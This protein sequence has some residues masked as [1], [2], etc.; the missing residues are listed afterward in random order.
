MIVVLGFDV[1]TDIG[2]WTPF[3]QGIEKG[4]PNLLGVL[5]D[6]EIKG[7]FFIT[8]DV[9]KKYPEAVKKIGIEGHEIGCHSLFHETIGDEMFPI[10]G[11]VPLLPEEIGGRIKKAT[12]IVEEIAAVKIKSFRAPRLWGSSKML[13]VLEDLGYLVDTSYPMFYHEK[14][15][16]P[17]HPNRDNWLEKGDMKILEIPIFADMAME[18]KDQ[19]HRDRDQ[20]PL[21]R[22]EGADVLIKHIENHQN[23]LKKKNIYPVFC[24]YFHPWEFT[25]M[26][27]GE[28]HYGEGS[29]RPDDFIVKNC[30]DKAIKEF[31]KL[32]NYFKNKGAKFMTATELAH[33]WDEINIKFLNIKKPF[34]NEVSDDKRNT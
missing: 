23:Y 17:Y 9:A 28:I 22:T 11:I 5:K 31:D 30:G 20:W 26:L 3:Y 19:Y 32:I 15:L 33:S 25:P 13:N 8:G 18:S 2:S 6:N 21:Y 16:M 29:V 24:F 34:K 4:L 10:P 12:D 14:Q 1:E 7:T 27:Q